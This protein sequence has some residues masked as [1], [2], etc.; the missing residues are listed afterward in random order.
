MAD[1][2][3]ASSITQIEISPNGILGQ[4]L[5]AETS[6][7]RRPKR[8]CLNDLPTA[9]FN[10]GTEDLHGRLSEASLG[11]WA[12]LATNSPSSDWFLF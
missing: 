6:F 9:A 3:M 12:A 7:S 11:C 5:G 2:L 10:R 8:I 1:E 4:R